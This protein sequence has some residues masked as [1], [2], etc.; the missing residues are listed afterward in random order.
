MRVKTG[1]EAGVL[2]DLA[3]RHGDFRRRRHRLETLLRPAGDHAPLRRDRRDLRPHAG[4]RL[5][6]VPERPRGRQRPVRD[7][8]G[9]RRRAGHR[10][11]ALL[12]QVHGAVDRRKA[13]AAR[14]LHAEALP[15]PDRQWLPRP[16]L[17]VGQGRQDQRLR[18]RRDGAR[19]VGEG[20]EFSRRH[21]EACLGTCR[22]HQPDGQF[23]QAHQRAAHHLGRHL[24][25]EYGDLDRQQP[26]PHG[27]RAGPG[28][29]R[30]APA[31]RRG[32][33]LSAAGGHHRG[34][35]RRHPRRRPIPASATTSTCTSMATR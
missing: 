13:R 31:R 18:R 30:A 7:E 19:P 22:D 3:G 14:D 9:L 16:H 11:Q 10:R 17:G 20:P 27:A 32:Q 33:S 2:P 4:A 8:L 23:L 29:L 15:G 35:S 25:A 28:P 6:A 24:G 12:L 21:H 5:G 26:H 1:V 34:R